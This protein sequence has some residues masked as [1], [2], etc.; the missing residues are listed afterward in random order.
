MRRESAVSL[1]G[2]GQL[3]GLDSKFGDAILRTGLEWFMTSG[4][5]TIIASEDVKRDCGDVT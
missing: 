4:E 3:I 1:A 5:D 2:K